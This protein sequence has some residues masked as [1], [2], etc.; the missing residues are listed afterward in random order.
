MRTLAT[1]QQINRAIT[2]SREAIPD[3]EFSFAVGDGISDSS[4]NP[5]DSN[6]SIW[7]Y[8]RKATD[9]SH[10]RLWLVPDFN[11]W[12]WDP[13]AG[14]F[15]DFQR[16]AH[17]YDVPLSAKKP[18]LIWRGALWVNEAIRGALIQQSQ[19]QEWS[20]VATFDWN[21]QTEVAARRISMSDHCRYAFAAHTE[22]RTWSGRLKYLLQCRSVAVV[23]QLEWMAWY[24]HLLVAEGEEQ[25]ILLVDREWSNLQEKM[26]YYLAHEE[27]AQ[28]V[29]DNAAKLFR[30]RYLTPAA[31]TCYWRRLFKGY[32]SVAFT[33]DPYLPLEPVPE[34]P[35]SWAQR[36]TQGWIGAGA[37][38]EVEDKPEERRF[39]GITYEEYM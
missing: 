33:P 3:I 20:D 29:A 32:A 30:D 25:N 18:Q 16:Q 2:T 13:V 37:Q 39:R 1:L 23:H 28:R 27:E 36:L 22:G 10:D 5:S 17:A 15:P 34:R 8:T 38:V 11:L 26:E 6:S 31:E 9:P 24:Y 7:A 21:N 35:K 19:G 14:S 4:D 12:S